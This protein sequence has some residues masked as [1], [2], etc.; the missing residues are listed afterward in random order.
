MYLGIYTG[1]FGI[2]TI[3]TSCIF[4]GS[5]LD[6]QTKACVLLEGSRD[7]VFFLTESREKY[8]KETG[9]DIGGQYM[10]IERGSTQVPG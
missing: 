8:P 2:S 5:S 7:S 6:E 4:S 3:L 9:W 1:S 10:Y